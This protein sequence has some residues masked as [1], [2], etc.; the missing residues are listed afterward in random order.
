MMKRQVEQ[1]GIHIKP[2]V[3]GELRENGTT[4]NIQIG[5]GATAQSLLAFGFRK[6]NGDRFVYSRGLGCDIS[7]SVTMKEADLNDIKIDVM[8]DDFGQPYD[9]QLYLLMDG[10]PVRVA[11]AIYEKVEAE[12]KKLQDA[13]IIQG[14]V[15]GNYV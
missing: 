13:G 1:E 9:Y 15:R 3:S 5:A 11:S 2:P 14:H 6:I 10:E 8:D 7:F 4:A 12:L